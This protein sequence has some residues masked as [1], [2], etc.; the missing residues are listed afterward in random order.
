MDHALPAEELAQVRTAIQGQLEAGMDFHALRTRAAGSH[1]FADCHVLVPGQ[2][3]VRDSHKVADRI[4]KAVHASFPDMDVTVHIE[5]IEEK[6]SWND[7]EL[8]PIEMASRKED[9]ANG[10]KREAEF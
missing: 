10:A 7:S 5:P 6:A 9:A 4:E 8:V 3:S 1:R 2:M